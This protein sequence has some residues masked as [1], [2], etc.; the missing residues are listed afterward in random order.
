MD[1][2]IVYDPLPQSKENFRHS[3]AVSKRDSVKEQFSA[4]FHILEAA[5][6]KILTAIEWKNNFLYSFTQIGLH[7][8]CFNVILVLGM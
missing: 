8:F 4:K 3:S 2:V 1:L 5:E 6:I 7:C